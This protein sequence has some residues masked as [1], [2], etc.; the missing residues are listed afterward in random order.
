MKGKETVTYGSAEGRVTLDAKQC[1]ATPRAFVTWIEVKIGPFHLDPCAVATT[2][3]APYFFGPPGYRPEHSEASWLGEDGLLQNWEVPT[4]SEPRV[5]CNPGYANV[6]PWLEKAVEECRARNAHV[7]VLTHASTSTWFRRFERLATRIWLPYPRVNFDTPTKGMK[8]ESNPR[9]SFL[10]EF[11][12]GFHDPA[13][14]Y[15]PKPWKVVG[16]RKVAV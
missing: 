10:W 13:R 6:E 3:K 7:M 2:K 11:R 4:I 14:I 5:F 15:V 8:G 16:S 9:D 12:R 1:W